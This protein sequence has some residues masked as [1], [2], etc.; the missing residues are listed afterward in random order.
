ME[1]DWGPVQTTRIASF[2]VATSSRQDLVDLAVAD[3]HAARGMDAP[4]APRLVFDINGQGVSMHATN[5]SYRQA[6][7]RADI[8]HA[9][10]G[11]VVTASR[12]LTKNPVAERSATTDMLLDLSERAAR[13]GLTF[14][15]LGGAEDVNARCADK[16]TELYPN[17]RIVGRRHGYFPEEEEEDIVAEI[18]RCAP[19]ILWVGLGKPKEQ[20]FSVKWRDGLRAGWLVTCGGCFNYVTGDYRRAP[21]WM[22]NA[23]LEWLH[24]MLTN[25]RQ[26]FWRYLTTT[27]HALFITLVRRDG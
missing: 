6:L 25:P 10:G 1:Q 5:A 24:R 3:C 20:V 19:D 17:L 7:E 22:Q 4:G 27:P 13:E 9:D 26:L 2:D 8:I 15:L 11:F 12:I 14:Y 21:E 23:N 16:L 18:N